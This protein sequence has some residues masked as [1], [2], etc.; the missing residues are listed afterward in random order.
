MSNQ[1]N[2]NGNELQLADGDLL[3]RVVTILDRARANV[4]RSVN[5]EMVVAYWLIG[6]E[7]VEAL[8]GGEDRAEYGERLIQDLSVRL[9]E[10]FGK[11]FSITNLKYCRIFYLAYADRRPEIRHTVCDELN[12]TEKCIAERG[13]EQ[14]LRLAIEESDSI[15][16]FSAKLS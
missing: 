12:T 6:R 14:D 9:T 10:I 3:H 11:G 15:L 4:V 1:H 13:S 8:Q 2:H 7:I 5:G 16:G